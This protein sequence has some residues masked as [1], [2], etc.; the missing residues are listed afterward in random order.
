[1]CRSDPQIP[2]IRSFSAAVSGAGVDSGNSAS[3]IGPPTAVSNASLGMVS[4]LYD[5]LTRLARESSHWWH[6]GAGGD[7][8]VFDVV[9]LVVRCS[10]DLAHTLGD[11]VHPVDVRLAQQPAIGVDGEFPTQREPFDGGEVFGLAAPA[12]SEFLELGEDEWR[13]MV[14]DEGGLN[15][16]GF[17]PES[18]HSRSATTPISGRPVM[19]LR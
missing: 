18:R 14:V 2:A 15:V 5:A 6:A 4:S 19:S 9:D 11:A 16:L 8:H 12:E 17:R 7:Q 13:E 1:M 10:T 3:A